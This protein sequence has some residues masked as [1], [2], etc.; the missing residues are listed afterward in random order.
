MRNH[1]WTINAIQDINLIWI[2]SWIRRLDSILNQCQDQQSADYKASCYKRGWWITGKLI[3]VDWR[4]TEQGSFLWQGARQWIRKLWNRAIR[5]SDGQLL[6]RRPIPRWNWRTSYITLH[7]VRRRPNWIFEVSSRLW[8]NNSY[9]D[10]PRRHCMEFSKLFTDKSK[11]RRP[12][13]RFK[14]DK[15]NS[16]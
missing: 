2:L 1:L 10:K 3:W 5:D 16:F 15:R 11:T 4:I 7:S 13:A 12:M 9:P 14:E 8:S 6:E